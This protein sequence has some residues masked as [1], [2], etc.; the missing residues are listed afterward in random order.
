MERGPS[1]R[2]SRH[3]QNV[4]GFLS[5]IAPARPISSQQR[6]SS[7]SSTS[8]RWSALS[9]WD[10][11]DVSELNL[12]ITSDFKVEEL[13]TQKPRTI[14]IDQ[15]RIIKIACILGLV[16][17]ASISLAAFG[18]GIALVQLDHQAV[19]EWLRRTVTSIGLQ[20]FFFS[21]PGPEY[22]PGHQPL[23]MPAAVMI[24]VPLFLNYA[25]TAILASLSFIQS[26][27]LRWALCR[28]GRL[29]FNSNPR[30]FIAARNH[31]PNSWFTNS[32]SVLS[33]IFV[34]GSLAV[35]STDINVLGYINAAGDNTDDSIPYRGINN[36]L[37]INGWALVVL[38]TCL[39]LQFVISAWCMLWD[40][41]L[42]KTWSENPMMVARACEQHQLSQAVRT[43]TQGSSE[44]STISNGSWMSKLSWKEKSTPI[45]GEL[46]ESHN[47]DYLQHSDDQIPL[48]PSA[49]TIIPKI[50]RITL[51]LWLF[52]GLLTI[53]VIAV[54]IIA[55]IKGTASASHA[56]YYGS[57]QLSSSRLWIWFGQLWFRYAD[58]DL[59]PKNHDGL[60]IVF[61]SLFQAP[62][63]LIL[64]STELLV[65]VIRD[66]RAWREAS[67]KKGAKV[68]ENMFVSMLKNWPSLILFLFKGL[69]Q[70]VFSC[71]V[72]VD[73]VVT[74][75]LLPLVTLAILILLLAIFSEKLSRWR[76]K[77][78]QPAT[79]GNLML[80][81][82]YMADLD[83]DRV[84]WVD[85]DT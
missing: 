2:Y 10:T 19:A 67:T 42:V 41:K 5:P 32:V 37:D 75:S 35:L 20:T 36:G 13:E 22:Y 31:A 49:R 71:V 65:D 80:L 8:F 25:I 39:L 44:V 18:Y 17:A 47:H 6:H 60:T 14:T 21:T 79:Y 76:P 72:A 81:S 57:N 74:V 9:I 1:S 52:F 11:L 85:T 3:S 58:L 82:R 24:L 69:T 63:T 83:S 27:T 43:S 45:P 28:E 12:D 26:T 70:W 73:A 4:D 55:H 33:L 66:E 48:Q 61:Q 51:L 23:Q 77:G 56:R 34:Y 15:G 7:Q 16:A 38:A 54:A 46:G 62:L 84:F 30:L 29:P 50:R 64:H 53:S 40:P 78:K 59:T 68:N